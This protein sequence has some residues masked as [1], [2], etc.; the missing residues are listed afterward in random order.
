ME[1]EAV[2]ITVANPEEKGPTP[3]DKLSEIIAA[4]KVTP[5]DSSA[6]FSKI[7]A[8]HS[9]DPQVKARRFSAKHIFSFVFLYV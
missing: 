4:H 2:E 6:A 9:P 3:S 1:P 8:M 5:V 7:V